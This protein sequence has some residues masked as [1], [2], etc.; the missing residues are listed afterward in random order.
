M[1]EF[2]II[3]VL[4]ETNRTD[5]E[6]VTREIDGNNFLMDN[7]QYAF[8]DAERLTEINYWIEER[9]EDQHA[10]PLELVS[11]TVESYT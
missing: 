4:N 11:Y 5:R 8:T 6:T 7:G 9:G 10:S 3:L 2:K 1:T